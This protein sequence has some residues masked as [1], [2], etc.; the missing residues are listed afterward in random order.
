MVHFITKHFTAL[1]HVVVCCPKQ[2]RCKLLEKIQV[3][4]LPILDVDE[5]YRDSNITILEKFVAD[6][7]KT[8]ADP[9]VT[10]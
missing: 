6:T 9:V 10:I 8:D 1:A 2:V 5:A 3:V 4:P 7:S